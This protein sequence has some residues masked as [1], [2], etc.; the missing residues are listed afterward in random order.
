LRIA[1]VE[2]TVFRIA[3]DRPEADGTIAWD[4]TTIVV[5]E[6]TSVDGLRSIGW[7][8][9]SEAAA[10]VIHEVLAPL[11]RFGEW[12][13]VRETWSAMVAAVRNVGRGGVAAMA[14]SAVDVALWDLEAKML[15]RP[16]FEVLG[17]FR[18]SVPIYGS[19]G[20]TSYSVDE[21]TEQLAGW[22]EA[23][24]PRVKMKIGTSWG[25]RIEV[26]RARIL[27]AR[28]AIGPTAELFIDAN[29]AYTAK[30]AIGLGRALD[31]VADYFEEPVSSDHLDELAMVRR[32]IGQDVAAGEYGWDPWYFRDMLAA[33]AV[34]VLQADVTRCLGV[35]GFLMAGEAAYSSGVRFS[36][37][38]SPTIHAHA[39]CAVP[40]ISHVEYFHDHVR[41]EN[42]LFD[43]V[44][45][46]HA[47][48]LTPPHRPGLGVE[49][50]RHDAERYRVA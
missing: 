20:F 18:R 32:A 35:T 41:I 49:L 17:P 3:T 42:M 34:D 11:V 8:Y 21:L 46:Q 12:H 24:I 9:A 7:T 22:V 23:G 50:K 2:T 39:A 36:A 16:L 26:D 15:Q 13:S 33:G 27:S 1:S 45:Q 48:T 29:G 5:V 31:G 30:Q 37:H 19:G 14:I 4:H 47:G 25:T 28:E 44:P 38:C 43:G 6:I 40:Q 10:V